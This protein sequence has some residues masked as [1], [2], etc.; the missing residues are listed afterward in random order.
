MFCN[1]LT[2]AGIVVSCDSAIFLVILTIHIPCGITC[3]IAGVVAM[4]SRKQHGRH[5]TFG[6]IYY[7][8]LSVVFVTASIMATLRWVED[9][10]LL[11]LGILSFAAASFGCTASR[12]GWVRLHISGMGLSY[13]LLL[14]AF[15]VDNGKSLPLWKELPAITYWI[16]PS[17]V[18]LPLIAH[19]LLHHPLVTRKGSDPD[20]Q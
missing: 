2:A 3:V 12:R 17:A 19:A 13:I 8:S 6:T 11:I 18:G 16:L 20:G 10:Y 1:A 4:L 5:P 9:Y 15:Y 7:W 14:T